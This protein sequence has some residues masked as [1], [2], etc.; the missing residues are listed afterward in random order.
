MT[1]QKTSAKIVENLL[2]A[3]VWVSVFNCIMRTDFNLLF[4]LLLYYLWVMDKEHVGGSIHIVV[5]LLGLCLFDLFWLISIGGV[6][7]KTFKQTHLWNSYQDWHTIV[8]GGTLV[9][10]ALK[11]ITV[12]FIDS[13]RK[14]HTEEA[15][16]LLPSH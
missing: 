6:W 9:N 3:M 13:F 16:K 5:I 12:C 10:M 7:V 8:I 4:L 11:V 1:D 14:K 2:F 15:S